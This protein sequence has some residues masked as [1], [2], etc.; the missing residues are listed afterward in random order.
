M[1]ARKTSSTRSRIQMSYRARFVCYSLM[2]VSAL[3]CSCGTVSA[4]DSISSSLI[5]AQSIL[6]PAPDAVGGGN[7]FQG[8]GRTDDPSPSRIPDSSSSQSPSST[9]D[10]Q[11]ISSGEREAKGWNSEEE[12]SSTNAENSKTDSTEVT[13]TPKEANAEKSK[14]DEKNPGAEEVSSSESKKGERESSLPTK[15]KQEESEKKVDSDTSGDKDLEKALS[16]VSKQ[17]GPEGGKSLLKALENYRA[18]KA[19][20]KTAKPAP[21]PQSGLVPPP[22]PEAVPDDSYSKVE[23]RPS[24]LLKPLA[25]L[26]SQQY[27]AA[28]TNLKSHLTSYPDDMQAH[29]LLGVTLVLSRNYEEARAQYEMVIDKS[30]DQSLVDKARQGLDKLSY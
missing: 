28:E 19:A 25:L 20:K 9:A 14:K 17:N 18:Q 23:E 4:H 13:G 24:P 27:A 2:G 10:D 16:A 3:I 29:Y 21:N 12:T 5:V 15:D 1:V 7:P 22:P 26:R 11:S 6:P 8:L 30:T